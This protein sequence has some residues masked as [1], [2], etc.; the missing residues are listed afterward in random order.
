MNTVALATLG[1]KVNQCETAYLEELLEGQ[2]FQILPFTE[3]VDLYC[4]NT[5]AVTGRAAME[6]RQFI[7]R[8]IRRNPKAQVV[9]LGC[10]PQV[11]S[12]EVTA[13]PGVTQV[14][15]TIEK[16]ELLNYLPFPE[17]NEL[18]GVH[19]QD[20]RKAPDAKPLTLFRFAR[21]T[22][23]FLKIQD[24]CNAF[25]S[26]CIVPYARGR[27]RSVTVASIL[28]QVQ[29][30]LA[31]GH[32]EIVLTGIHLGHWG[33]D[34]TPRQDLDALVGQVLDHCPPP[35]LRLSSLEPGEITAGLLD[36]LATSPRLCPHLHVPLQSGDED[37]LRL[38]NRHYH[39]NLYRDLVM[40]ATRRVPDLALGADVL[41]GFPGENDESFQTTYRFI[42]SLPIAYL[43]VFP[44]SPRP[45]TPAATMRDQVSPAVIR[46]RCHRLRELDRI[47]RLSFMQRYLG[48]TRPV[49]VENRLYDQGDMLCGF[50]DNYLP[51]LVQSDLSLGNRIILA[52][53]HRLHGNRLIARPI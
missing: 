40:E 6:S 31:H 14:L 53:F 27:S 38:M 45:G 30:F 42:D 48:K 37:V 9:V 46:R 15:G 17:E 51:V 39:P 1:C 44:F 20:A 47:K 18:P 43:H 50:S 13:I 8:A 21:R 11:A 7:R 33:A 12:E 23:A 32:Q 19:V 5:C 4:I 28:E 16:L 3:K 52:R 35:R 22:R 34:L 41:V 36:L 24:G 2:G 26:Y 29:Q 25:C 10:Y 49:L